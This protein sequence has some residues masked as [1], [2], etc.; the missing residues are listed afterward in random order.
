MPLQRRGRTRGCA[1]RTRPT[2][3]STS[4]SHT[5]PKGI[6]TPHRKKERESGDR[7]S[8]NKYICREQWLCATGALHRGGRSTNSVGP[9]C[10]D[11][12]SPQ[13]VLTLAFIPWPS[14]RACGPVHGTTHLARSL[15]LADAFTGSSL[16]TAFRAATWSSTGWG[17]ARA[18]VAKGTKVA[19]SHAASGRNADKLEPGPGLD[20]SDDAWSTCRAR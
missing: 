8:T 9:R 6:M 13:K 12:E 3:H 4:P 16:P 5:C 17:V 15:A 7:E 1:A 2:P 18:A 20:C 11:Q 19:S 14:L 10:S